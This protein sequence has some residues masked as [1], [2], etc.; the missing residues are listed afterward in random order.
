MHLLFLLVVSAQRF[1]KAIFSEN[2]ILDF[3]ESAQPN[4]TKIAFFYNVNSN[5]KSI[6]LNQTNLNL[7]SSYLT[8]NTG[9]N[10]GSYVKYFKSPNFRHYA[11]SKYFV[12]D[13]LGAWC[14]NESTL[15]K[16]ENYSLNLMKS[17]T[18]VWK[19]ILNHCF[20]KGTNIKLYDYSAMLPSVFPINFM[21]V[22]TWIETNLLNYKKHCTQSTYSL[23]HDEIKC[24]AFSNVDCSPPFI[25]N[26]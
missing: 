26:T 12:N 2:I 23:T 16:W 9:V 20:Q 25:N 19:N 3:A 1:T 18:F 14:M 7:L 4:D 11:Y 22:F 13:W 10:P 8:I 5:N 6:P 17:P 21:Y 24:C 15:E